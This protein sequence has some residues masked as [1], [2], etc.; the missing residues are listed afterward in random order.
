MVQ[1]L[2]ERVYMG[3][4]RAK[5]GETPKAGDMTINT[6]AIVQRVTIKAK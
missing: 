3:A 2:E 6:F 1:F 5:E 4:G